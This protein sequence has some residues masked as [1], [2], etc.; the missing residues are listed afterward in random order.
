MT[1]RGA[2]NGTAVVVVNLYQEES[3]VV[4]FSVLTDTGDNSSHSEDQDTEFFSGESATAKRVQPG[5]LSRGA[6]TV[7]WLETRGDAGYA[8]SDRPSFVVA[9]SPQAER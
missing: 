4:L 6:S 3:L 9:R 5:Q 7:A 8:G 2:Q 1:K